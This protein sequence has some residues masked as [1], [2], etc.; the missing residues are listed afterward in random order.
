[1]GLVTVFWLLMT[2]G[3]GKLVFQ[4]AGE[5]R[6]VVDC[7]VKLVEGDDHETTT[8]FSVVRTTVRDGGIL[9]NLIVA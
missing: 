8:E 2:T 7:N 6:F 1:M 5:I 4:T 3:E 9:E